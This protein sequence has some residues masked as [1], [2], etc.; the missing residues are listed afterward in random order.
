VALDER[1]AEE[2]EDAEGKQPRGR[3]HLVLRHHVQAGAG[4]TTGR[5]V[6]L[7]GDFTGK[8]HR[9]ARLEGQQGGHRSLIERDH[10]DEAKRGRLALLLP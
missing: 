3:R 8:A 10:R 1:Q 6:H 4:L 7:R 2:D 9:V 5:G